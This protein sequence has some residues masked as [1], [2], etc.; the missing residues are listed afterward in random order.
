MSVT[1][2]SDLDLT[3]KRVL[4]RQDL[5][6]PIKDGRVTSD[7]RILAS[8]PTL[9]AALEQGA[10]VMVTSHLGRPVEGQWSEADSLAPVAARLGELMGRDIPLV[11][12]YLDGVQV[13][14]GELVMLEN[15]RMNI[16]EGKD[17]PAL[18]SMVAGKG[19]QRQRGVAQER[20]AVLAAGALPT[21]HERY[22]ISAQA[23][24]GRIR[25]W[26]G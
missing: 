1:R 15:C 2:M 8:I 9:K 21:L 3:G 11:R 10:A 18:R 13:A 17:D 12:D 24:A 25:R 20:D 23:L 7:Q 14:P 5:N 4:I 22:G 26:L 19:I 16:G 6:V